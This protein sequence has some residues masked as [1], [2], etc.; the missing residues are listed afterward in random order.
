MVTG[1]F[2]SLIKKDLLLNVSSGVLTADKHA[3]TS[4]ESGK[5]LGKGYHELRRSKKNP[6]LSICLLFDG[7]FLLMH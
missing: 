3:G 4:Q 1:S 5:I 6:L 2:W 7:N